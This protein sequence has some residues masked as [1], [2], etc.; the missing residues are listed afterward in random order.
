[1]LIKSKKKLDNLKDNRKLIG[2]HLKLKD[3]NN[4]LMIKLNQR[5][6]YQRKLKLLSKL[7]NRKMDKS[8]LRKKNINLKQLKLIEF[9][10]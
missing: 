8:K 1:M 10:N 4:V 3:K 7:K 5:C 2:K 6:I 9:H